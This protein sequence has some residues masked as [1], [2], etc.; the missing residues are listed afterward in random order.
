MRFSMI[1]RRRATGERASRAGDGGGDKKRE[2]G[3][4]TDLEP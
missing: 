2:D 4:A 3:A 1:V